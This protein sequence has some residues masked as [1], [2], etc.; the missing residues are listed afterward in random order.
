MPFLETI[1]STN[2]RKEVSK[3]MLCVAQITYQLP[4][5]LILKLSHVVHLQS[6]R[7]KHAELRGIE[8]RAFSL[9]SKPVKANL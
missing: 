3:G 7:Q 9:K 5:F 4:F 6:F 2:R 8:Y 1:Y